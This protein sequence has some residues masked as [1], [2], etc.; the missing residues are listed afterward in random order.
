MAEAHFDEAKASRRIPSIAPFRDDDW[1]DLLDYME[2]GK[3]L[4]VVGEGVVAFGEHDTPLYPH[5][6][7][8]LIERLQIR[9][10]RLS[11][12]PT[13]GEVAS[14]HL[15]RGGDRNLIY[16]RIH[17]I[18]QS[19][20]PTAGSALVQ[21][22]EIDAFN[23]YLTTTFD[24]LLANAIVRARGSRCTTLAFCPN[25][26]DKDLP[27]RTAQLDNPA[28]YHLLGRA[29]VAAG[30]FVVWEEDLLDFLS[31]LPRHLGTDTMRNL[32]ADLR[33][34]AL[35]AVGLR[36]S[37]WVLR[38]LLR[39]ARQETLSQ[40]RQYSW[41]AEGS[42]TDVAPSSIMFFGT[43]NRQIQVVEC[44]SP[45]A[46]VAELHRRWRERH[47]ARL[48]PPPKLG[49][50]RRPVFISYAREDEAAAHRIESRLREYGCSVY[51][52]RERLGSGMNFQH[53][54]AD[55]VEEQCS[56]FISVVSNLTESAEGDHYFRLERNWA[57]KRLERFAEA[58]QPAFYI[59]VCI[60]EQVPGQLKRE[61]RAVR[62]FQWVHCPNGDVSPEFARRVAQL[63]LRMGGNLP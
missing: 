11:A 62:N 39:I 41:F 17:R 9:T 24:D 49:L 48:A 12:T 56:M 37:D 16:S 6:A 35:L 18:L 31:E 14:E 28:V 2:Q 45:S 57:A 50:E 55:Q 54:L 32:S 46:F 34:F 5:L 7:T 3:V 10:S 43:I 59:P 20:M 51:F 8:R 27:C 29:S 47:P 40:V 53:E 21:L 15:L 4:P 1:C 44:G 19:E 60:Q 42:E 61:P 23:L 22:A 36:F 38:L 63:Q 13:L 26:S 30:E 33:S 52:D 25:A 58:D